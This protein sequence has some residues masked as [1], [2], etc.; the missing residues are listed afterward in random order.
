MTEVVHVTPAPDPG[1]TLLRDGRPAIVLHRLQK[2]AGSPAVRVTDTLPCGA[3]ETTLN[4]DATRRRWR[5]PSCRMAYDPGA[6]A[7][8]VTEHVADGIRAGKARREK[9]SRARQIARGAP[10]ASVV[11]V[12]A[13]ADGGALSR[14]VLLGTVTGPERRALSWV[15]RHDGARPLS[16][17]R[18]RDA[19]RSLANVTPGRLP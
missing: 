6:L 2:M 12:R 3:C 15:L 9:G 5:C 11:L 16:A 19:A 10:G 1:A 7:D 18:C 13:A 8:L 4:Y 14:A 17:E